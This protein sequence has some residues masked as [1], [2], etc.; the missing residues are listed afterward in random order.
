MANAENINRLWGSI[1]DL[2]ELELKE[3]DLG[4]AHTLQMV[5]QQLKTVRDAM[6][7]DRENRLA[8]MYREVNE[9]L[10]KKG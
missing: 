3:Y 9:S 7:T 10:E 8:K 4:K 6:V 5:I 1:Q 2:A